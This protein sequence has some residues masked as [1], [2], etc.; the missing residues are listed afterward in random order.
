MRICIYQYMVPRC[1]LPFVQLWNSR[2]RAA[3]GQVWCSTRA[4]RQ[5]RSLVACGGKSKINAA[6][7][8]YRAWQRPGAR[9]ASSTWRRISAAA[10]PLSAACP[11]RTWQAAWPERVRGKPLDKARAHGLFL[12]LND[13]AWLDML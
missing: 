6:A 11:L 10:A 3:N 12:G 5:P 2:Q 1:S 8:Q 9:A 7:R 13:Y 4:S